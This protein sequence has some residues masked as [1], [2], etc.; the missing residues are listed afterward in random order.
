ML[1]AKAGAHDEGGAPSEV[2]LGERGVGVD[3]V[4]HVQDV[5]A[6]H[7]QGRLHHARG[8]PAE[9]APLLGC[10]TCPGAANEV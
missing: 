9:Q 6:L 7:L 5:V 3:V 8:P 1:K 2:D 4:A 10:G